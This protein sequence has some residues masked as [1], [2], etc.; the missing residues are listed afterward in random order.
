MGL[1]IFRLIG[2]LPLEVSI[3]DTGVSVLDFSCLCSMSVGSISY[4]PVEM[5]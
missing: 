4:S 5:A 2:N 1:I 3:N